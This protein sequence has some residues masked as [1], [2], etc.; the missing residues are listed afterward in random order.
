MEHRFDN[1]VV[2]ITGA[3]AG[4]G[5][6][7]ALFFAKKGAKVVVNDLGTSHQGTGLN[8]KAADSVVAEI[9]AAGGHAVA[10]YDSAEE[11]DKIIKTAIDAYGRVDVLINNAGILRDKSFKKMT[12]E[13]W[14]LIVRVHLN[15]VFACTKAAYPYMQKQNYG[16]IINVSSPA[17]LY[18]AFG[19]VNY[20]MA[21]SGMLGFTTSMAREGAKNNIFSNVIAPIAATRMTETVMSKDIL[22][23]LKVEYIVPLV[24]FLAHENC[25]ENGSIFEIGGRWIAKLRWQ[26]SEGQF[27]L[28]DMTP[29]EIEKHWTEITQFDKNTTYPTETSSGMQVMTEAAEKALTVKGN[30]VAKA[31]LKSGETIE[32]IRNYLGGEEGKALVGKVASVFQ[33]DILEKKGGKPILVFAIDLLNGNGAL[34]DGAPEKFDAKFT[35]TDEDFFKVTN[36]TLNPQMAFIQGKM[37]I[38]GSMAKAT[39]FTPD[40][41]PKPTKENIEKYSKSKAKF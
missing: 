40:L 6:S 31:T 19:Q 1:K 20:S 34:K 14:D 5:K 16:R 41:F 13:D 10:N 39:K 24:A 27:F 17:G 8:S 28:N 21:K 29:E 32:L 30:K 15:A 9:K 12:K 3:G 11:G 26:R 18:G 2:V 25:K 35:M 7:Y 23:M 33:F 38:Q 22:A 4:L 36:G 37:K